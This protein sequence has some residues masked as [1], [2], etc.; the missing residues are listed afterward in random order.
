KAEEPAAP[1]AASPAP[2]AKTPV[3]PPGLKSKPASQVRRLNQDAPVVMPT[4]TSALERVG[5]QFGSFSLNDDTEPATET[6]AAPAEPEQPAAAQPAAQPAAAQ[7]SQP[8]QPAQ[9]AATTP[10][11]AAATTNQPSTQTAQ[12]QQ[13]Q[14]QQQP[15]QQQQQQQQQGYGRQPSI[16]S[17][18]SG[19]QGAT[20]VTSGQSP[21]A[22]Y[23]KQDPSATY[24]QHH[25]LPGMGHEAM[26]SPYS[27]LH[28]PSQLG[29][30]NM[31]PMGSLPNEYAALYGNDIQRAMYYDPASYGQFPAGNTNYGQSRDGKFNQDS[32]STVSTTGASHSATTSQAGQQ[33]LQQ[34][35]AQQ[36]AYPNLGGMPYYPYYYMAPNQ[37][38][39]A[40]QQSGYGQPFKNMYPMYQHTQQ[41]S[42]KPGAGTSSPYGNYSSTGGQG[43]HQ[44]GQSG[45]DDMS[46]G[47]F[48]GMQGMGL[49]NDPYGKYGNPG[50]Q[51]F[52][53]S[54]QQP[55]TPNANANSGKANS[56]SG[57]YSGSGD[58]NASGGS[59]PSSG[60]Q[61]AGGNAL[62]GQQPGGGMNQGNQ[63]G[64]YQQ[65][66]FS[67]YQYPS[68][69]Q[70]YH[71]N[72]HQGQHGSG[73]NQQYWSQN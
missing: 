39:N 31:G 28:N 71:P 40:Y 73:R 14:P 25:P 6:P 24:G 52:L 67:S 34:Q 2:A 61:M 58:K 29:G 68:H 38:P 66:M 72:Q 30:F 16:P 42:N 51:N 57:N 26:G 12:T 46:A 48:N 20:P 22:S 37:F 7:P 53:G 43:H 19:Y 13:T 32:S 41:H 59:Q 15:Q 50:M 69:H 21:A 11:T 5:V 47:G 8:A 65:Q 17:G 45:Y 33:T 23:L 56:N 36:Q 27:Y 49:G 64:Y 62:Q 3:G 63:Q 1:A 60:S 55:V 54:Q 70:G 4:K 10:S 9:P 44:Y 35:Q 18:G